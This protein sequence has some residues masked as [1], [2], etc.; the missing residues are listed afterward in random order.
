MRKTHALIQVVLALME[1]PDGRHWGYELSKQSGVRSG[2]LYPMLRRMLDDGWLEDGWEE[3]SEATGKR[4]P[5]RYY[6]L[7]AE[8]QAA[9]VAILSEARQDARFRAL[10]GRPA[11]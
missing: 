10:V 4:P 5:R 7:N 1:D 6:K 8:G 11:L 2:V 3:P 9:A